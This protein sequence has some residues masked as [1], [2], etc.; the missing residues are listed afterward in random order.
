[1]KYKNKTDRCCTSSG[2]LLFA[3]A[4][5]PRCLPVRSVPRQLIFCCG[6]SEQTRGVQL[7]AG[8]ILKT[9]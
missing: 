6:K 7:R 9:S 2:F 5:I 4:S 3:V 1:M 8:Y